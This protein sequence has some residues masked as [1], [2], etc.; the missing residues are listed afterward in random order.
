MGG[1]SWNETTLKNGADH[2]K[3]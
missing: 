1:I 3:C 2:E